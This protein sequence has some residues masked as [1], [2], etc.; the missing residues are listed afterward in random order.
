MTV[1]VL[2]PIEGSN[3]ARG[4]IAVVLVGSLE[5]A[6]ECLLVRRGQWKET[7]PSP[8][9]IIDRKRFVK[10]GSDVAYAQLKAP[11]ECSGPHC[12]VVIR[13]DAVFA[14]CSVTIATSERNGRS[15]GAEPGGEIV[16]PLQICRWEYSNWH[17]GESISV[18]VKPRADFMS[19]VQGSDV[20]VTVVAADEVIDGTDSLVNSL[21]VGVE[22][23]TFQALLARSRWAPGVTYL[24]SFRDAIIDVQNGIVLFDK[25]RKAWGDSCVATVLSR[26]GRSRSPCL[27]PYEGKLAWIAEGAEVEDCPSTRPAIMLYHWASRVNYGHWLMNSLLSIYCVLDELQ[28]GEAVLLCPPISDRHRGE[29]VRMGVPQDTIVET[30]SQY[31]HVSRL[32]YPSPLATRANIQPSTFS[33][34]FFAYVKR[35]FAVSADRHGSPEYIYITRK[36]FPTLRQMVNEDEVIECM[37]RLGLTCIAPHELSFEEQIHSVSNAKLIVG[38]LGAALWNIPFMPKGGRVVEICTDNYTTNEYF[39]I[40]HLMEHRF[41]R[42]MVKPETAGSSF[43]FVAPIQQLREIVSALKSG[44]D[45]EVG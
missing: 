20:D 33:E 45:T 22:L 44:V 13:S 30:S 32:I 4:N 18:N 37:E 31:T 29:I 39:Y 17:V 5:G 16:Y 24:A 21:S 6:E 15:G 1:E 11:A 41:V 34:K 35:H 19:G 43:R 36:G 3:I 42:V 8:D 2:R 26:D 38:Q 7:M 25:G 28:K 23:P 14:I 10:Y 40:S 27:V 12:V 9:A